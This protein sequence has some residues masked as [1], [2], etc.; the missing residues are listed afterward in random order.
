MSASD[1][2]ER[3]DLKYREDTLKVRVRDGVE[4]YYESTGDGPVVTTLNNFF[5][6][7][8][9]WRVLTDDLANDHRV[10]SYDLAGHGQS[11]HPETYPSWAQH[12]A[13]A[14]ALLDALQVEKTYLVST[15]ISTVLARDIALTYPD[16]VAGIVLAGPALG[17]KGMRRHRQIQRAWL[18]TLENHGMAALYNH[19]Y[20]EVFGADMNEELGTPGFLGLRESFL[21]LSTKEDL[22]NGLNLALTGETS[23]ELLKQ[24]QCPALVVIG[25][26]DI[27]LSNTGARELAEHF[28]K[29]GYEIMP[30]AGHLPFLDDAMGFQAIVRK[31]V[32]EAE[33]GA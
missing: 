12:A 25:D 6:T 31:F 24:I 19:L 23:P 1:V 18:L 26:D 10:I 5:M 32:A 3:L 2:L 14:I 30:G 16:R 21:A 20:P 22:A 11:T 27:L 29:G 28:P 4:L 33:A 17:P 15:S 8:P 7:T 13:D 9:T